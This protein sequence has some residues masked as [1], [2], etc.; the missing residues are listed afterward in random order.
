M[1]LRKQIFLL[2][3]AMLLLI[4]AG[5]L[6]ISIRST[7]DYL[8]KQLAVHAQ[9]TA[10][11]LGLSLAP[12]IRAGDEARA[13]SMIDA[14]FD[15]GYYR[16]IVLDAGPAGFRIER[17]LE[18]WT[19]R[20]PGWFVD[21][22][23]LATPEQHTEILVDWNRRARLSV[24]IHPGHA[25]DEL[26]KITRNNMLWL[27]LVTL[28]IVLLVLYGLRR[29][30]QPL[31]R[32][33]QQALAIAERRYQLQ[34]QLPRARELRNVVSAMNLMS[35]KVQASIES[36][37]EQARRYQQL[38]Y[39]DPLTGL[40]NRR[41][42]LTELAD[43]VG[44]REDFGNAAVFIL[45]LTGLDNANQRYGYDYGDAALKTIA[46]CLRAPEVDEQRT[47]CA[48]IGGSDFGLLLKN[49]Q[50]GEVRERVEA[51][52]TCHTLHADS[53]YPGD[54]FIGVSVFDERKAVREVLS[55]A[56]QACR[57][58]EAFASKRWHLFEQQAAPVRTAGEWQARLSEALEKDDFELHAQPIHYF[59]RQGPALSEVLLR[60]REAGQS[61]P[62][63]VF[64]P[65]A[66]AEG[67]LP[68]IDRRVVERMLAR[69][70]LRP[71]HVHALNLNI[72]SLEDAAFFDWLLA[73]LK[74]A[75]ERARCLLFE[76]AEAG[77]LRGAGMQERLRR[78]AACCA[79]VAVERFGAGQQDFGYLTGLELRYLKISGYYMQ[80]IEDN[81]EHQFYLRT[82]L[83]M[84]HELGLD[85]IAESVET[86]GMA[87]V[88]RTLGFDAIQGY[89]VGH[90][91]PIDEGG[92]AA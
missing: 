58:A 33:E 30:L 92:T 37:V 47:V 86:A 48:R 38:A 39:R 23:T 10:T 70:D 44:H 6:S 41:A 16:S 40:G 13:R 35:E 57:Q 34:T 81:S 27:S 15:R 5:M 61:V 59:D 91:R 76:V 79:G 74:A 73:S 78:L 11:S 22:L 62:A 75:G 25:Y 17:K 26:W 67:M 55:E 72:A 31:Q 46:E 89:H 4:Y 24:S 53:R 3:A 60:L 66:R 52:L 77:Q 84:G 50:A 65:A 8:D 90:P 87:S 29:L 14:I 63:S 68:L 54:L 42:F 7:Q 18:V 64:L 21:L 1:S 43:F 85:M 32:T 56:D 36:Q 83:Q 69:E 45:H 71:D 20:A 49:P 28:L 88:A 82:L 51:L 80:D 2:L 9:D 19:P 12:V